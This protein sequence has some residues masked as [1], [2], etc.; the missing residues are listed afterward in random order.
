MRITTINAGS[1]GRS[2][3]R[4]IDINYG[5]LSAYGHDIGTPSPWSHLASSSSPFLRASIG[6]REAMGSGRRKV[7][8]VATVC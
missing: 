8:C 2:R 5:A 3:F 1:D 7:E 6:G 4:E